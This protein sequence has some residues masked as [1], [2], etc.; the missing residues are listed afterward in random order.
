[1]TSEE[2]SLSSRLWDAIV[3]S[4]DGDYPT[5]EAVQKA[6]PRLK[7]HTLAYWGGLVS[8]GDEDS[9]ATMERLVGDAAVR[10]ALTNSARLGESCALYVEESPHGM[11]PPPTHTRTV[12]EQSRQL[13][14]FF[15]APLPLRTHTQ[16]TGCSAVR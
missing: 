9:R 12:L 1:M 7:N 13:A 4:F 16:R 2:M 8:A 15:P 3:A 6:F 11:P 14:V 5:V 10:G